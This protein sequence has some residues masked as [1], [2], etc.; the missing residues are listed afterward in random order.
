MTCSQVLSQLLSQRAQ[1]VSEGR[2]DSRLI[3]LA[4]GFESTNIKELKRLYLICAPAILAADQVSWVAQ[5]TIKCVNF[6]EAL[7][8]ESKIG[9]SEVTKT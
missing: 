5:Y 9:K 7:M 6:L 2:G 8:Q 3:E 4:E 1:W